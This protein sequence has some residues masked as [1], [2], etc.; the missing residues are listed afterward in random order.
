MTPQR[1]AEEAD[2]VTRPFRRLR[3]DEAFLSLCRFISIPFNSF[4]HRDNP[5]WCCGHNRHT[6]IRAGTTL[7]NVHQYYHHS[8]A[9]DV[10]LYVYD[11]SQVC[12]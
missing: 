2:T 3:T 8:F 6:Y 7:V 11:L 10:Q 9:M 4:Y 5:C 1:E 12:F